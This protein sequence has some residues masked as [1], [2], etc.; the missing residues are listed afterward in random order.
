MGALGGG[1]SSDPGPSGRVLR[2]SGGRFDKGWQGAGW[3]NKC[4]VPWA[5]GAACVWVAVT[6]GGMLGGAGGEL[7]G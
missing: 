3:H 5:L 1:G 6:P 7:C 4:P 2:T